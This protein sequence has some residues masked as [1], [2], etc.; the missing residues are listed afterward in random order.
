MNTNH[1]PAPT[2]VDQLRETVLAMRFVR[3]IGGGTKNGLS[4]EGNLSSRGLTGIV[5]YLPDEYTMTVRAGTPL[6]EIRAALDENHQYLPFDPP[7]ASA[8]ATIG[9]TVA[10]GASGP[11]RFRYGGVR[12]FLLG[13]T[14][15]TGDGRIVSGGGKVVKNSAGFDIPKLMVGG[16][17]M[18]G[19]LTEMTLKVFPRSAC[20]L[21]A[22]VSTESWSEAIRLTLM[23]AAL[24]LDLLCLELEPPNKIILRVGGQPTSI[25][26]R[27]HRIRQLVGG[28]DWQEHD[29][30]E[31][32]WDQRANFSWAA[33]DGTHE[34]L[35]RVP[36]RPSQLAAAEQVFQSKSE[37]GTLPRCYGVGGNVMWCAGPSDEL[38]SALNEVTMRLETPGLTFRGMTQPNF[39]QKPETPFAARLRSVFDPQGRFEFQQLTTQSNRNTPS[40]T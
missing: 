15:M 40:A 9:G 8:G 32:F 6:S 13:L 22:V 34:N 18:W 4:R 37:W 29:D 20:T 17:G 27:A 35:V 36:I 11:G 7:W 25:G 23:L 19:V 12:D 30:D 26:A 28:A 16:L 1:L 21:T 3:M 31:A 5:D 39:N 14:L 33:G 2:S 10:A 24:P 38:E